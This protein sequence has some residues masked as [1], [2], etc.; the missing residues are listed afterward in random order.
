MI[1]LLNAIGS[2]GY[3]Y[4][5]RNIKKINI[6][7]FFPIIFLWTFILGFQYDVGT[8]Y[9]NYLKIYNSESELTYY[10]YK[11]EF[12]FF[13]FVK[14]L[15][16]F[17]EN[18]QILFILVSLFE[19]L[20]FFYYLKLMINNQ[21]ISKEKIYLFVFLFLCFGTN[22][23]NQ[24]NG[25]RQYFNI[26]LLSIS[27]FYIYNKEIF[28]YALLFIIGT[29][30]HRS[31]LFLIPF[32]LIKYISKL[33]NSKNLKFL[34]FISLLLNF[35]PIVEFLKTLFSYIPRYSHYIESPFFKELG[36]T[37]KITKFIYLPYYL[38]SCSLINEDDNS[39]KQFILKVGLL[40]YIIK[41]FCLKVVILSRIGEYF[42]LL[43]IYPIFLLLEKY[44]KKKNYIN[45]AILLGI[46]IGLFI[47]KVII[48]PR[49]EYLYR[50][51]LFN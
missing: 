4:V 16:F 49:G 11:K 18:G 31:F 45:L 21:L 15:K 3:L 51:Y 7:Y 32:Y 22:F 36:I 12:I 48:F 39:I 24:M 30:I 34:I 19:N 29:N 14:F 25:I 17:F 40:S 13:Y 20:L 33:L 28:K 26:Y 50:S 2:C 41:I 42:T 47:V 5:T 44:I 43:A 8:D 37:Q 1:F 23:Y 9:F 38:S 6:L 35:L 27:I 46:I 10:F